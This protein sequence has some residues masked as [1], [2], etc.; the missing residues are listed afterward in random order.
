MTALVP[1]NFH[2]AIQSRL[3]EGR[4]PRFGPMLML[5]ARPSLLLLAQGITLLLFM[6]LN[7]PNAAVVVRNWWTVYGTLVDLGCLGLLIWLTKREGIQLRDLIGFAKNKL[8]TDI[9]LGLGIIFIV[10]PVT[11]FGFGRLAMLIAY[12]SLNPIF[13]E[14]TFTRTLPLLAV[15]Y[16]RILWWILWSATEEMTYNGYA[17]PR[18]NAVTRSPWLSVALVSFFFS[19]Q[20]SFLPWVNPQYGLYMFILFLPLTIAL[21]LIYLRVRRLTPLFIGHWLMDLFSTLF[22][23]QIG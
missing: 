23:L 2:E 17:L 21:Q 7:I 20:H 8:K 19:L 10:F 18:L 5:F 4:I 12:G 9:P 3:A 22:M 6:Q 13:P 14:A 1:V 11:V 15:L 16:S